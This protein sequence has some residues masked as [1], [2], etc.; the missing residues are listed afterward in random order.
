MNLRSCHSYVGSSSL[1]AEL[2]PA[3]TSFDTSCAAS[4]LSL[5][6]FLRA[7]VYPNLAYFSLI[8]MKIIFLKTSG[9]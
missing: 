2:W 5:V 9:K 1:P 4:K 8:T 6:E 7:K 3:G